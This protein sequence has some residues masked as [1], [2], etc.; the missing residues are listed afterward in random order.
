MT[1]KFSIKFVNDFAPQFSRII[2]KEMDQEE[3]GDKQT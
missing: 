2:V 1:L 3:E